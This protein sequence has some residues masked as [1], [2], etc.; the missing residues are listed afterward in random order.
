MA[1]APAKKKVGLG[2]SA[3]PADGTSAP[4][5]FQRGFRHILV[6]D[7]GGAKKA[8]PLSTDTQR[9]VPTVAGGTSFGPAIIRAAREG[10][11]LRVPAPLPP[12][13]G[14]NLNCLKRALGL[15]AHPFGREGLK[16]RRL[17]TPQTDLVVFS[18][19]AEP[20]KHRARDYAQAV[21]RSR[22]RSRGS[23]SVPRGRRCRAVRPWDNCRLDLHSFPAGARFPA[24]ASKRA[25]CLLRSCGT[26]TSLT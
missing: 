3:A 25:R 7:N 20:V 4:N 6:H 9:P 23:V 26:E 16:A 22:R 5:E 21:H 10:P 2:E 24:A 17:A 1:R 19:A 18:D 13:Q 12:S 8:T 11:R 15:L 14:T